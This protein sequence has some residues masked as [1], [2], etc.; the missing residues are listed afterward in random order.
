MCGRASLTKNEKELENRFG[1]TFYSEDIERYNP[2]PN[3]N[4]APG[5]YFPVI[6]N[7][8][9]S[10]FNIFKWGLVP[11]WSK[12]SKNYFNLINA[13]SENIDKNKIFQGAFNTRRCLI[14]L[15]GFYEWDKTKKAKQPYR[16]IKM[17]REIFS[18]AGIW[19]SW[20]DKN[21]NELFTFSILTV[22][23]N[24]IVGKFH[25]RMPAILFENEEKIWI[26]QQIKS[27]EVKSIL[28]PFPSELMY[29]YPV[30]RKLNNVKNNSQDLIVE[31]P[32]DNIIEQSI[33]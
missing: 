7:S 21:G 4:I 28:K 14:P 22:K 6:T 10:H 33:F 18:V 24:E 32:E 2:I 16:F 1:S 17:D 20:K 27:E 13:R 31:S 3:F 9:P 29:A 12:D 30:S 26:D 19:E 23:A 8:D 11:Y 5:Q 15:D 25:D